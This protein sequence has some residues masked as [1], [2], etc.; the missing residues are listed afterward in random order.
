MSIEVK[1][2]NV[3]TSQG[4]LKAYADICF[5]GNVTVKGC[6]VVEGKNGL[7]L[8]MPQSKG[9][10]EKYYPIVILETED[11]RSEVHRVVVSHYRNVVGMYEG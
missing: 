2:M 5:N 10:D 9:K 11:F 6:K 1:R 4:S 7:F 8:S 3:Q